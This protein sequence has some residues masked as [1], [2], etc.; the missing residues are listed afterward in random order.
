MFQEIAEYKV[1]TFVIQNG[2]YYKV[3]FDEKTV[4]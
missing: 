2:E 1:N 4:R 3:S